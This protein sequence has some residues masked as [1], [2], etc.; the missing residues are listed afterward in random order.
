VS[1]DGQSFLVLKSA[2]EPEP[3]HTELVVVQEFD[4]EL[5]RLVPVN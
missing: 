1:P 3:Q 2:T 5:K 4:E